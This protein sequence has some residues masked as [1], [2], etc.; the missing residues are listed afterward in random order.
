MVLSDYK[1]CHIPKSEVNKNQLEWDIYS[2]HLSMMTLLSCLFF[3]CLL[4][5][6]LT[7]RTV[8][9]F[10]FLLHNNYRTTLFLPEQ[11][12]HKSTES[13]QRFAI[14]HLY[15]ITYYIGTYEFLRS[16]LA[17][18]CSRL[19]TNFMNKS[20][21]RNKRKSETDTIISR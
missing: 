13:L 9:M 14:L 20:G 3:F 10:F 8:N 4:F 11:S 12:R 19:Q 15:H 21:Y 2:W 1:L 16:F 17:S 5:S 7:D 6:I 18:V